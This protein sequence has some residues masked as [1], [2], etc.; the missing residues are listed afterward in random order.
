[1]Y[2]HTQFFQA[3]YSA[4]DAHIFYVHVLTHGPHPQ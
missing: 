4:I 1:M 2:A 3:H